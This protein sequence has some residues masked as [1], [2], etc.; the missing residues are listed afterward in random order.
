MLQHYKVALI[1]MYSEMGN[2]AYNVAKAERYIRQAAANNAKL[3]LLPEMFHSGINFNNMREGMNYAERVDGPTLTQ[4][5][6]IASELSVF[7]LCP[8]LVDTGNQHWENTAFLIGGCGEIL[9]SYAKTH[10]VGDER[11]LLQRGTRYPVFDTVLGKIGISI[12]YDVCFPETTRLLALHGAEIVLVTA[13]WRGSH[14]FKEWWDINLS[15]RAIDNLVYVAAVNACGYT[16]DGTEIYAGKSQVINPI[17]QVQKMAGMEEVILYQ[18]IYPGRV[19]ED[20]AF[21]SVLTDRH[22]EDYREIWDSSL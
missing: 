19:A 12:C 22:A 14:Y 11:I 5:R 6:S 3:I 1:Q 8:I 16:G 20:R 4:I 15:C 18:E 9:G 21:N 13:G 2:V 7:I 17:G 10:P